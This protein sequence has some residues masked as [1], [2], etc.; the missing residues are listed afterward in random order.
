MGVGKA[1]SDKEELE[2]LEALEDE[3]LKKSKRGRI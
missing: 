3:Q 2:I 1:M